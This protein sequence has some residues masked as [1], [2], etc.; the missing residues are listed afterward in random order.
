[1][2]RLQQLL[3]DACARGTVLGAVALV[4]R[5]G[6]PELA[7]AGEQTIGGAAMT[8]DTIFRIASITK[9]IVAAATMVLVER[10]VIDLDESV[11]WL[12]PELADPVVL[13]N[14]EGPTDDVMPAE[15]AITVRDLLTFQAGHGFP[16]RF[17]LPIVQVLTEQLAEGPPQPQHHP[18]PDDWMR[19]LSTV[20]LLHQPGAGW[21]YNTGADILGV[22]LSRATGESLI[23]VLS[24][25]VLG[26]LRMTDT[27]FWTTDVDRL[28]GL[29]RR[30]DAGL[31]L[32]DP[33]Q[34]QWAAPPAF[35]SGGGGLLSTVHD[36]HRFGRMILA[37]GDQ[38]GRRVLS[39]ESVKLITT[40][41]V[42]GGPQHLFLDGQG[43]GFGGAVDLRTAHPW[44]VI[45]RY[46]WVG[47][48]GTAGYV[49]GSTQ[50][51]VVWLSQVEMGGPDDTAAMS[52]VLTY[53][54]R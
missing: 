12:L 42:D 11:A 38:G 49:I 14:L 50:T 6:E 21:T 17:D 18:A 26:P 48:T 15:R 19:A 23:D 5:D 39:E 54:A 20:P 3:D 32:I 36:W 29:Y 45:G 25:A 22:L 30:G 24:D 31:E 4:S 40:A 7:Y 13:R 9:P 35:E 10:G 41:H 52:D 44:N 47:G 16:Q 43:W 28:A 1:M 53:A 8:P 46:G 51:V 34:G 37:G 2:K 27:S 33:P